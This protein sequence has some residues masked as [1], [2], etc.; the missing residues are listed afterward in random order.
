MNAG[1]E[2][3]ATSLGGARSLLSLSTTRRILS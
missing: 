1:A 2:P 3:S